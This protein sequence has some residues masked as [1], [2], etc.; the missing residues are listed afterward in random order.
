MTNISIWQLAQYIGDRKRC[1]IEGQAVLDAGYLISC[2]VEESEK[3]DEVTIMVLG[4]WSNNWNWKLK[5]VISKDAFS[6]QYSCKA[7]LE[8]C[9]HVY[10][11]SE[12]WH[13]HKWQWVLW[14]NF[15]ENK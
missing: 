11:P 15:V 4:V 9:K 1:A 5:A 10:S 13:I 14:G 7:G 2:G 8:T 12:F 3:T 6:V